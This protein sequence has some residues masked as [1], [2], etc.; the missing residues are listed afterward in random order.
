MALS[1]AGPFF[2]LLLGGAAW[3]L[4]RAW[5]PQPTSISEWVVEMFQLTS[6][7]WA[8]FNL[9]PILPL[10]GGNIMLAAI[11]GIRK[12]PSAA[13]ASWISAAIA[14]VAALIAFQRRNTLMAIWCALYAVQNG[15]RA[16]ALRGEIP[17]RRL[18]P[19][20]S[21]RRCQ[22]APIRSSRPTSR[23]RPTAS[24]RP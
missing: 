11:E 10:D 9:L 13:L 7:V 15:M 3:L 20:R 14:G 18:P 8:I 4:E 16:Q 17:R 1:F 6:V 23:R 24:A 12:K 2:G 21:R 5:P 19:D 22:P